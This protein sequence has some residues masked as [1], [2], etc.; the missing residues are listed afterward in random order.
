L[1]PR[2]NPWRYD[3][4]L[5]CTA[6]QEPPAA[7]AADVLPMECERWM[8]AAEAAAATSG[9]DGQPFSRKHCTQ[10]AAIAGQMKRVGLLPPAPDR[11]YVEVNLTQTPSTRRCSV[12]GLVMQCTVVLQRGLHGEARWLSTRGAVHRR[13]QL[14]VRQLHLLP[15]LV[16]EVRLTDGRGARLPVGDGVRGVGR[17]AHGAGGAP[18][19]PL[20]G[21]A[22]HAQAREQQCVLQ[23]ET[24]R[25]C[26]RAVI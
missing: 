8:A 7:A 26:M 22:E 25:V 6:V 21:G 20:Q 2:S 24:G 11:S 10:Q 4:Q 23:L 15:S 16:W 18:G 3:S 9:L 1:S 13:H 17:A 5:L 12:G 19:V 14:P